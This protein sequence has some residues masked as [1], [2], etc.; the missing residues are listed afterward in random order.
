MPIYNVRTKRGTLIPVEAPEGTPQNSIL[1]TALRM[2]AE[3]NL[4]QGPVTAAPDPDQGD[5][6]RS[7]DVYRKQWPGLYGAA[8]AGIG[9]QFGWE[10]M[11]KSGLEQMQESEKAVSPL[12]KPTDSIQGAWDE[13]IFSVVTDFAPYWAGQGVGMLAELGLMYVGGTLVGAA[14]GNVPGAATGGFAAMIT[15]KAAKAGIMANA[16]RIL[17]EKG[18]KE[19]AEYTKKATANITAKYLASDEGK[20]V[21]KKEMRR[22]GQKYALGSL[23]AKYGLGEVYQ[24]A[25]GEATK[26][27]EDPAE[28][29]QAVKD[30]N[31]TKLG[32]VSWAHAY[33]N[34]LGFR[35]LRKSYDKLTKPTRSVLLNIAKSQAAAGVMEGPIEVLQSALERFGADLPLADK[36]AFAEYINA[37]AAGIAMPLVPATIGG[38]RTPTAR[39]ITKGEPTDAIPQTDVTKVTDETTVDEGKLPTQSKAQVDAEILSNAQLDEDLA[40]LKEGLERAEVIT[41]ANQERIEAYEAEQARR[42]ADLDLYEDYEP[43][44]LPTSVE[45]PRPETPVVEEAVETTTFVNPE[46][47]GRTQGDIQAELNNAM[48]ARDATDDFGNVEDPTVTDYIEELEQELA[49]RQLVEQDAE[50]IRQEDAETGPKQTIPADSSM[51]DIPNEEVQRTIAEYDAQDREDNEALAGTAET[52]RTAIDEP[53]TKKSLLENGFKKG[54]PEYKSA[55]VGLLSDPQNYLYYEKLANKQ[56]NISD[57]DAVQEQR[58]NNVIDASNKTL[59]SVERPTD[60]II[61]YRIGNEPEVSREAIEQQEGEKHDAREQRRSAFNARVPQPYVGTTGEGSAI[62]RKPESDPTTEGTKKFDRAG[63]D[64]RTS[65]L[66]AT[67]GRARELATPLRGEELEKQLKA[68]GQRIRNL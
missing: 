31:S 43:Q 28:Q 22:I 2:E 34:L 10:G 64:G 61:D 17:K 27:I 38:L 68:F 65:Y 53:I 49:D 41:P 24:T 1:Q 66:P 40:I 42:A 25:I 29:L 18:K 50:I 6:M 20:N 39:P 14:A 46:F 37:L 44:P 36:E 57:I 23:Y 47:E 63:V 60:A 30:L 45:T 16:K 21:F 56:V 35:I 59:N 48:L 55:P 33:A 62:S 12:S 26:D 4:A 13:G 19:A 51:R 15:R 58:L 54:W 52:L 8:K 5:F 32:L 11:T 67:A 3:Q 9:Q 7:L